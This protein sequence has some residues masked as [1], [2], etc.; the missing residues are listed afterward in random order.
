M[1]TI[2][3]YTDAYYSE[4]FSMT[5]PAPFT[6]CA[7]MGDGETPFGCEA[8][9]GAA[10]EEAGCVCKQGPDFVLPTTVTTATDV[11]IDCGSFS[12]EQC[13]AYLPLCA[14]DTPGQCDMPTNPALM[15]ES[16]GSLSYDSVVC[17]GAAFAFDESS[18]DAPQA[19]LDCMSV[20]DCSALA[21]T[22][23]SFFNSADYELDCTF[24]CNGYGVQS[25]SQVVSVTY[26]VDG[27]VDEDDFAAGIAM[28]L[29]VPVE[30]VSVDASVSG[31]VAVWVVVP[32]G[33]ASAATVDNL[34]TTLADSDNLPDDLAV[35][36]VTKAPSA[37]KFDAAASALET[38][39]LLFASLLLLVAFSW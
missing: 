30:W 9:T 7:A 5:S 2:Y 16:E 32:A 26:G 29:G 20:S 1:Y 15:G 4:C 27:A 10:G 25:S 24:D 22:Y 14:V 12:D 6:T 18:C 8:C 35:T 28:T 13:A 17:L 21:E 36:G 34:E 39:R 23:C 37:E 31:E 33:E 38:S 11:T 19:F 3:A